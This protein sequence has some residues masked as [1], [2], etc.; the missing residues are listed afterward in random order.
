MIRAVA[1]VGGLFSVCLIS[2][3]FAQTTQRASKDDAALIVDG[4]VQ[5]VFSGS[6]QSRTES[7]V[8]IEVQQSTARRAAP[9]R[10]RVPAPGEIVYV[11]VFAQ[12]QAALLSKTDGKQRR[13]PRVER[14]SPASA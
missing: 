9:S 13:R 6:G 2:P 3:A 11:H 10:V 1:V 8:Q 14:R 5:K 12:P 4:V 7:L